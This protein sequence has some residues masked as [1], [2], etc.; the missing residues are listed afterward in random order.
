MKKKLPVI[1]HSLFFYILF[2]IGCAY[3]P[4][5]NLFQISEN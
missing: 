3:P 2:Y 4:S 5:F 1:L